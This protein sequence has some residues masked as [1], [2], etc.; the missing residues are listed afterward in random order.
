MSLISESDILFEKDIVLVD[1]NEDNL[2]VV[3]HI[4]NRIGYK[5]V[6]SFSKPEIVIDELKASGRVP[7]LFILDVMMPIIDGITLAKNIVEDEFFSGSYIIFATA[8]DV[9]ETLEECF[10]AGCRD[11]VRKPISYVE[12]RCRVS[13]V[14]ELQNVQ[15]NLK[16]QNEALK[17]TSV[18]DALT[19]LSNR[20]FLDERLADEFNKC[21]R[22]HHELSFLMLDLD[23][24]KKV[25]DTYV[26]QI[27]DDVL[28]E[29]GAILR[30][31]VRSTDVVA[32]YGGEEFSIMLTS[33]P[34]NRA[35][36]F[37]DR[38]RLRVEKHLSI[39]SAPDLAVTVSI[40]LS[41]FERGMEK[42]EDL[43]LRADKAL[44]KA[45]HEGRNKV[46]A[47]S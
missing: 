43:L 1:D 16:K 38:L 31:A 5:N 24:F 18:T 28:V 21:Q 32:R 12:L 17:K 29:M 30:D 35:I 47:D 37:A 11:F 27:G 39:P 25:N 10:D 7:D 6:S 45:K 46:V 19:Q 4:L 42:V 2:V 34:K 22:Y 40:G 15:L 9:N 33:T 13:N 8:R 41:A 23:H 3:K 44:Y 14:L 36:E 20:R 26:H